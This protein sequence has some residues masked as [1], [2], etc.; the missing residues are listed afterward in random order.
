MSTAAQELLKA[1]DALP[2]AEQQEVAMA[3]LRRPEPTDDLP[4][5]ALHEL[6]DE[7]FRSYDAEEAKSA[8]SAAIAD[9]LPGRSD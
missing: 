3:I 7:L 4:E 2:A 9:V 8:P 6:A 1:F 5:A